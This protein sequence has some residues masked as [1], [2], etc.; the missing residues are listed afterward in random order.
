MALVFDP[1]T[2]WNP[3]FGAT[4]HLMSTLYGYEGSQ[5]LDRF[6]KKIGLKRQ[7]LQDA[8]HPARE[9]YDLMGG[10][11]QKA[12]D[13]G[14]KQISR[15]ELVALMKEKTARYQARQEELSK[16]P[17]PQNMPQTHNRVE[18]EVL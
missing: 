14:A 15:Q 4:S 13:A 5:E 8:G 16:L 9:H 10:R 18:E 2:V 12:I 11:L 17:K 6:A 3:K 1:P 7:W